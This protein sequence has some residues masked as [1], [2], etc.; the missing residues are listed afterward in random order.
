MLPTGGITDKNAGEFIRAGAVAVGLGSWL[1]S[2]DEA[3]A[4]RWQPLRERL[5]VLREALAKAKASMK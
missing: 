2:E 1:V 3:I 4:K 5:R